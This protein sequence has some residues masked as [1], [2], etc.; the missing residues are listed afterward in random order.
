MG[1]KSRDRIVFEQP[2]G[3]TKPNHL[4][5]WP[6]RWS[7][8]LHARY[9]WLLA[10]LMPTIDYEHAACAGESDLFFQEYPT[11]KQLA[12][13]QNICSTCPILKQC[14]NWSVHQEEF[15]FWAGTTAEE[16]ADIR[17]R[18]KVNVVEPTNTHWFGL[19]EDWRHQLP[20]KCKNGHDLKP[21]YDFV[22][23]EQPVDD[24]YRHVYS[25]NCSQC[26]HARFESDEAKEKQRAKARLATKKL[27]EVS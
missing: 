24:P 22:R 23:V 15:G 10:A 8:R 7:W 6:R 12:E 13:M 20:K 3:A 19:N 5:V 4:G 17:R 16:R 14:L 25:I 18:L 26:Y 27:N 11:N 2:P 21:D 1:R 9:G